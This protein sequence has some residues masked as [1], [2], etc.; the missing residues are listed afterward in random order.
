VGQ[1]RQGVAAVGR[2]GGTAHLAA[3]LQPGDD[4]G[5]ARQAGSD[6]LTPSSITR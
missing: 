6:A 1:A 5:Q 4:L 3:L 2:I